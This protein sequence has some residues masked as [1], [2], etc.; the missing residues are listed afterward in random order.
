MSLN[1]EALLGGKVME[2]VM[3]N[4]HK[5][6]CWCN[7]VDAL[8]FLV[9]I[10]FIIL[11]IFPSSHSNFSFSFVYIL[12]S[13]KIFLKLNDWKSFFVLYVLQIFSFLDI[14]KMGTITFKQVFP[15]LSNPLMF[16]PCISHFLSKCKYFLFSK[17][18]IFCNIETMAPCWMITC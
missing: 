14:E 5:Y 9:L 3:H 2:S 15:S 10:D 18:K 16:L 12:C 8:I 17:P 1:C 13:F 7:H 11:S 6:R 4:G